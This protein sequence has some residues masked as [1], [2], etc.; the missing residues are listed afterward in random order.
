MRL[1]KLQIKCAFFFLCSN[2]FNVGM[3][4]NVLTIFSPGNLKENVLFSIKILHFIYLIW[5][6][7]VLKPWKW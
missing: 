4:T 1:D 3:V 5:L 2:S 7:L 6:I